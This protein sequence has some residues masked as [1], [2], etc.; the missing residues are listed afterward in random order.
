ML[1][2]YRGADGDIEPIEFKCENFG[3]PN[4]TTTGEKMFDNTHFLTEEQAWNSINRSWEAGVH[5]ITISLRE[6]RE[7]VQKYTDMLT[8]EVLKAQ[9]SK[10]KYRAWIIDNKRR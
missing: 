2:G 5:L 8:D 9:E 7:K 1:K 3:Y 6:A 10:E 4:L